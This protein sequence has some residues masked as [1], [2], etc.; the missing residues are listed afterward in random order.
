[1]KSARAAFFAL[2]LVLPVAASPVLA[3]PAADQATLGQFVPAASPQPAPNVDFT[4]PAGKAVTLEEFAGKLVLVNLWATWCAPCRREMPSLERLQ[5]R[6]GAKITI[7]AISEDMGGSKAVDPFVARLG[8]K[9]VKIYLD[10]KNAVSQAFKVDGLP[11]SLLID[12]RGRVLGRVEGE[13]DWVS[14]KMLG[15]IEPFLP[16]DDIV[17]TSFPQAHP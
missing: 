7:L 14:P 16:A 12:R 8:L 11:T 2:L 15:V 1:M 17:K 3:E 10:P 13:A 9:A 5:T 6:L 4:D